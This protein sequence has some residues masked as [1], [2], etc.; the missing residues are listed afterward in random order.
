MSLPKSVARAPETTASAT[1]AV[2]ATS[3]ANTDALSSPASC[4][5][6]SAVQ[7]AAVRAM[8]SRLDVTG[9]VYTLR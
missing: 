5:P 9:L 6:T 8:Q 3:L 1:K 7:P 2:D 4:R